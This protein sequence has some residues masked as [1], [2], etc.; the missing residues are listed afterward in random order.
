MRKNSKMIF[1]GLTALV[2]L[3]AVG[4]ALAQPQPR[5]GMQGKA[6]GLRPLVQNEKLQQDLSL[7]ADQI[8]RLRQIDKKTRIAAIENRAQLQIK[9]L[10]L[11]DL[12]AAKAP[13]RAAIDRKVQ[14]IS[15]LRTAQM[16]D[17][18]EIRLA[19]NSILSAEQMAKLKELRREAARNRLQRRPMGPRQQMGPPQGGNPPPLPPRPPE[20]M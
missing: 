12:L 3:L 9:H 1:L 4:A 16:K 17:G 7:T 10:E 2:L 18:I 13:D 5:Q 6:I 11:Q 19:L 20:S 8:D 15:S 14:E